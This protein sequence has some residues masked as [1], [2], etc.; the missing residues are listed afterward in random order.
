MALSLMLLI[1]SGLFLRSLQGAT[2]ID[3][4]FDQP[5]NLALLSVDPEL[6]GY[7][8][9]D[10]RVFQ[11]Q[12]MERVAALPGVVSAGAGDWLP[13]GLNTS[14]RGATVPGYD[15]TEGERRSFLYG[16]VR[17]GYIEALGMDLIE[18]RTFTAQDDGSG[19]PVIIINRRFAERFWPGES[20][21]GK[22]VETAGAEREVI[23]VVGDRQIEKPGRGP[24]G[25]H[26]PSPARTLFG[27]SHRSG[28]DGRGPRD[29]APGDSRGGSGAGSGHARL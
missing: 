23:G 9:E 22:I 28:T 12:L 13:L 16:N 27:L 4:G 26:A 19:P 7:S 24:D 11:D 25:V 29:G 3:P 17:E 5:A 15:Y 2:Q 18:G 14:D 21:L 6:Q 10:A 8:E 1:S 20:A